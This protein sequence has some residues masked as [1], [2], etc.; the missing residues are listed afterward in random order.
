[1]SS[2]WKKVVIVLSVLVF[3]Y[4]AVGYVKGKSGGDKSYVSLTVY[5]EVLQRIQDDYVD[6]PDI[7]QVTSG[8]LHGLL[9]ALDPQSSYLSPRDGCL[10]ER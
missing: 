5:S 10:R 1:M 2:F 3:A 4:V 7:H 9:D 8:A 6:Q